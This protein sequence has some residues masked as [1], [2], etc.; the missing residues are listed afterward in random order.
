MRRINPTVFTDS[1]LGPFS[2]K[3][4]PRLEQG[5]GPAVPLGWIRPETAGFFLVL[6]WGIVQISTFTPAEW[7]HPLW[8]VAVTF[9]VI[10]G[11]GVAQSRS[12]LEK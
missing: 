6:G 10:L 8:A 9:A 2:V 7:H 4:T 12:S 11:V 5:E 1:G 3:C